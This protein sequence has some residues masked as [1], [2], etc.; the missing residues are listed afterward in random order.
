MFY[1]ISIE[2]YDFEVKL[3]DWAPVDY[4]INSAKKEGAD[5]RVKDI[6]NE[7]LDALTEE[8]YIA[9]LAAIEE[10]RNDYY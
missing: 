4:D 6:D 3:T 9:H 5:V 2:D 10:S 7:I 1:K 8:V